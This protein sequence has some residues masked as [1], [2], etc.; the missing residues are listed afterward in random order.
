M[1]E[2]E[3]VTITTAATL[4]T[5]KTSATKSTQTSVRTCII[6]QTGILSANKTVLRTRKTAITT[7]QLK[8]DIYNNKSKQ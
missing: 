5:T 2:R 1:G 6:A 3:I 8:N 4:T 7:T